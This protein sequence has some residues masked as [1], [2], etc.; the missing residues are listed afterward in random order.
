M[1]ALAASLLAVALA[2]AGYGV[3]IVPSAT[4]EVEFLV[5]RVCFIGAAIAIAAAF[6][7]WLADNRRKA[8]AGF[9]APVAL[10]SSTAIALGISIWWALSWI[11]SR[12]RLITPEFNQTILLECEWAQL[13]ELVPRYGV[14][15][16]EL[17]GGEMAG[18]FVFSSLP[19][20]AKAIWG[21]KDAP[22]YAYLCQFTNFGTKPVLNVEAD[23]TVNF[24]EVIIGENGTSSGEIISTHEFTTARANLGTGDNGIWGFYVRNYSDR[25]AEVLLPKTASVPSL[26][27]G[28]KT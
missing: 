3:S 13:P 4:T 23:L 17:V 26:K 14:R 11:N 6:F 28:Y 20:G 18:A 25:Y 22:R 19:P 8:I 15:E 9:G 24:R 10:G 12:E 27:W 16:L 2:V 21:G 7:F 5:A 1:R